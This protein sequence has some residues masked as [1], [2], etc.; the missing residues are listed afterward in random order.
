MAAP[1]AAGVAGPVIEDMTDSGTEVDPYKVKSILMSSAK[2]L[3]N[4]P[5]VQ[6]AGRRR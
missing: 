5:F 1:M 4:D 3:K 2:D 6:G